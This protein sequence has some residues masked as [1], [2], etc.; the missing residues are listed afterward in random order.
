M[1]VGRTLVQRTWGTRARVYCTR[2][3][4]AM[5]TQ[6]QL[7]RTSQRAVQRKG[8]MQSGRAVKAQ[9]SRRPR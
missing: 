9:H 4:R 1:T 3:H 6:Q 5:R 8:D 7:R 2:P